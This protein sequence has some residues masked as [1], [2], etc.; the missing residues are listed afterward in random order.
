MFFITTD[1]IKLVRYELPLED[2]PPYAV[3]SHTW[4]YNEIKHQDLAGGKGLPTNKEGHKKL[5][6][7]CRIAREHGLEYLWCNT[8]CTDFTHPKEVSQSINS[9]FQLFGSSTIC[10]AHLADVDA[11]SS[12]TIDSTGQ[13]VT[14][15]LP[16]RL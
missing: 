6:Q 4:G 1:T 13:I 12:N 16:E 2:A 8:C 7:A 5:A 10:I 14:S 11:P 15:R 9:S 3:L